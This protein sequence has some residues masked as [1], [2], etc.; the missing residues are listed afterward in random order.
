MHP[1]SISSLV[2]VW[3]RGRE[4]RQVLHTHPAH[5]DPTRPAGHRQHRPERVRWLLLHQPAV[6]PPLSARKRR[7]RQNPSV[8]PSHNNDDY[9]LKHLSIYC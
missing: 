6:P 3:Q 4:L 7:M 2:T 5:A 9:K 8:T 1:H